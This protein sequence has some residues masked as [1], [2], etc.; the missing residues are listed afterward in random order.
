M[1]YLKQDE[2]KCTYNSLL[3]V[4]I[5]FNLQMRILQ[6]DGTLIKNASFAKLHAAR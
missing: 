5:A 3:N 4:D 2:H 6:F 1:K